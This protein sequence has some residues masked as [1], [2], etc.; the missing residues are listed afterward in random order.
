MLSLSM[1]LLI[2]DS[3]WDT[4]LIRHVLKNTP[5]AGSY[6][7]TVESRRAV[8]YVR[9]G[10]VRPDIVL[11]DLRL[12]VVTGLEVLAELRANLVWRDVPVVAMFDPVDAKVAARAQQFPQ[13]TTI[14]K[15]VAG[16]S[17]QL[18]A[19]MRQLI[20]DRW[21]PIGA[22]AEANGITADPINLRLHL[23]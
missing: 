6:V 12:E 11:L 22:S 14:E 10:V 18:L 23:A 1:I 3:E 20:A 4:A 8:N 2:T 5:A 9:T 21:T 7:R 16:F 19:R 17:S 15:R 13:V